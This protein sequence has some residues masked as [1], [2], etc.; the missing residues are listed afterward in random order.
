MSAMQTATFA[1]E[2]AS[3]KAI[4]KFVSRA[5]G[6]AGLDEQATYAVQ[7][8]VDE[9]CSNIIEHA[10]GDELAGDIVCTLEVTPESLTVIL[11]DRGRCFDPTQVAKPCLDA[12]LKDRLLG[13]LGVYFMHK[14]MDR[15]DHRFEPG[16]GNVLTMVKQ[17]TPSP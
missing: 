3:L 6:V 9:A 2:F 1:G 10:Y 16:T 7:M 11:R 8:A 13:G 12:S 17:R 15:V 4:G 14:L 5:A